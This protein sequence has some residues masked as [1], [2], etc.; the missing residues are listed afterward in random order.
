MLLLQNA[1][2][3]KN[4]LNARE[5]AENLLIFLFL[6]ENA[7]EEDDL[8]KPSQIPLLNVSKHIAI[9]QKLQKKLFFLEL[10]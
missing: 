5:T 3:G 4:F 10:K 9:E 6:K 2:R 8:Q 7:E 1:R